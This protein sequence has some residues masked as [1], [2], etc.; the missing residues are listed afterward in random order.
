[1]SRFAFLIIMWRYIQANAI[2][3]GEKFLDKNVVLVDEQQ[4]IDVLHISE[5]PFQN[6]IPI[7]VYDG[8]LV[9]GFV[10]AH[11]HLEL[12]YLHRQIE[13]HQGMISFIKQMM[14]KRPVADKNIV[15]ENIIEWDKRMQENGICAVGDIVNTLD[16]IEV[17]KKSRIYYHNFIEMFGLKKEYADEIMHRA[18]HVYD[19]FRYERFNSSIVPHAPYSISFPLWLKYFELDESMV[20]L[21]SFHFMESLSEK[22]FVEMD[23]EI[24][25]SDMLE[26]FENELCIERE[27][28]KLLL[29]HLFEI[30]INYFVKSNQIILVHNTYL[31]IQYLSMIKSSVSMEKVYFCLCPRANLWIENK[32]PN[33]SCLTEYFNQIC[34]GTDSLAS[35]DNL[36]IVDEMN[37]LIQYFDID[38]DTIL[39]WGTSNGANALKINDRYGY[40][41]KGYLLPLNVIKIE[42]NN[43]YH[44][45]SL[46]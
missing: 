5:M 12:S 24:G 33:I 25:Y 16:T 13:P 20:N 11:C 1:M 40:I 23:F 7:E 14:Q 31:D 45:K 15:Y 46:W 39:K 44:L 26:Y 34:I 43:I 4:I 42:H 38:I 3:D 8:I 30:L 17:K 41:K 36:S 10:N 32:L 9:P 22:K 27:D 6:D 18:L 28:L 29:N 35:N 2:F 19:Q 37:T 21:S